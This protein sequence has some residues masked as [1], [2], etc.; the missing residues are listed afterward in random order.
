M[1]NEKMLEDAERIA[2]IFDLGVV[3]DNDDFTKMVDIVTAM[4]HYIAV[5]KVPNPF[6]GEEPADIA[7]VF[8]IAIDHFETESDPDYDADV[9]DIVRED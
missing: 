3:N 8:R 9:G 6:T 1:I 2:R 4:M 5:N 7:D